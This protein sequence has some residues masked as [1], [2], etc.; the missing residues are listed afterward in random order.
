MLE[1]VTFSYI[2]DYK[3]YSCDDL[4]IDNVVCKLGQYDCGLFV[5]KKGMY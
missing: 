2:H 1:L 3:V 4:D 5:F